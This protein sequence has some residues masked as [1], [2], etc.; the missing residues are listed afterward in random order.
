MGIDVESLVFDN[1]V[2]LMK[3]MKNIEEELNAL[4]RS[5]F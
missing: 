4:R 1:E 3:K 5:L 2:E